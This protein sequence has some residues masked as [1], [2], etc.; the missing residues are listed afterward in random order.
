MP[1]PE[2]IT[3]HYLRTDGPHQLHCPGMNEGSPEQLVTLTVN[4]GSIRQLTCDVLSGKKC[5]NGSKERRTEHVR[6][7]YFPRCPLAKNL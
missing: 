3:E 5:R 7:G 2:S 1:T 6:D 4:G